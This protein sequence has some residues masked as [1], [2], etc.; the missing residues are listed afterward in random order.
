MDLSIIILQHNTRELLKDCLDSIKKT[1]IFNRA[2]DYTLEV[3]VSDNGS[4]D[5]SIEMVKEDFPWVKLKENGQNLGF[6]KGNNAALPLTTGR[7][8][9][10][11]NSDTQVLPKTL[12]EMIRLMDQNQNFG[13]ATCYLELQRTGGLDFNSHRGFPTPWTSLTYFSGL[14]KIFPQ[15][16]LFGSYYQTYKDLSA[17]HEVDVI[18]GAFMM[19]RRE[20]AEG[21]ALATNIWW[22]EDF[23]FYGEDI[24]FCYRLKK[25]GYKIVYYPKVKTTH[26]KGATHGFNKQ[27]VAK[28]STEDRRKLVKATTS[29]MKIFYQ[30]HYQKTY[31]RWLTSL[32]FLAI[33]VLSYVR[34][35]KRGI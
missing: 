20:A 12:T 17:T 22:D 31:P 34:N 19:V 30:K 8:V 9:L 6:A 28:L 5:G 35:L 21:I 4:T 11:L 15:T 2:S 7:Y 25:A 14:Y 26:Y 29:A 10:F 23:F 24:D 3:I 18:E 1:D 33:E 32:V 16:R 27:G 13:A